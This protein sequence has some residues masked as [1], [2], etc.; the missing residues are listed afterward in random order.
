MR[1]SEEE[2][3]TLVSLYY[4]GKTVSEICQEH[5]ISRSTF[6]TWIQAGLSKPRTVPVPLLRKTLTAFSAA[7]KNRSKLS[8]F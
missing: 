2:K 1:Y 8:R 5:Q 3:R 6:Y 7:A 4:N